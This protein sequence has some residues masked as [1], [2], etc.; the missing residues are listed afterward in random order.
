MRVFN[1]FPEK[2]NETGML[3]DD[4]V[5]EVTAEERYCGHCDRIRS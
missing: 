1:Q 3:K 5:K 2:Q 4:S